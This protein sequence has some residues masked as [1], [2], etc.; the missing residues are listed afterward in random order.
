MAAAG[1]LV[2]ELVIALPFLAV[3]PATVRGV[4]GPV[5]VLLGMGSAFV[6]GPRIGVGLTVVAVV[7]AV[8]IVGEN[9]VSE[10]LVWLPAA[11]IAGLAGD[12][13][14]R[15]DQLRRELLE[16]LRQ[17]LVSLVR[18]PEVRS[19]L[20]VSRYV[21]AEQAQ[22]LAGDFYGAIQQPSGRVSVMVGDVAG[23]GPRAAAVATRLRAT[24]RGL[25]SAEVAPEATVRVLND[26]LVADRERHGTPI[27]FATICLV[28]IDPDGAEASVLLAG[29]PPPVLLAE[30]LVEECRTG[31][32]NPAIGVLDSA[33]W[34]SFQVMLPAAPWT[35]VLYTDGLV[36]GR[37]SPGGPR[38]YGIERL[39]HLLALH[40]PPVTETDAD[41]I[42]AA[43]REANGG[44]LGDDMVFLAA[45]PR[46]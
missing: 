3:S 26:L 20:L 40:P 35:L 7:L 44:P 6:L 27:T 1:V 15:G 30:G 37:V 9:P 5:L 22:V 16:S 43:I 41:A 13:V 25:A 23:H 2:A 32:S 34:K 33:D 17:G 38:P 29:H 45:S 46:T 11:V 19:L 10:P 36:E 18:D 28:S 4:P 14:R 24:W 39:L 42:V 31:A 8:T 12:R 21:P